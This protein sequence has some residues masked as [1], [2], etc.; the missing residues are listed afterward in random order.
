MEALS[1]EEKREAVIRVEIAL[2]R[3]IDKLS[4]RSESAMT[5]VATNLLTALRDVSDDIVIG[6]DDDL[7]A[8]LASGRSLIKRWEERLGERLYPAERLN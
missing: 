4:E 2:C 1:A 5:Q 7:T 8:L 6:A 3:L